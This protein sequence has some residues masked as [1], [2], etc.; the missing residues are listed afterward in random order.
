MAYSDEQVARVC[1]EANKALQYIHEDPAPSH[2]WN[3]EPDEIRQSVIDGVRRVRRGTTPRQNHEAWREYRMARGWTYGPEK[4][5]EQK[6]HPSLV[7]YDELPQAERDKNQMF[8]L[9]VTSLTVGPLLEVTVRGYQ[10][11]GQRA[12]DQ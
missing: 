6:T 12:A 2:P 3:C 7:P 10:D 9:I 11:H 1:H 4:D 5:P 8:L